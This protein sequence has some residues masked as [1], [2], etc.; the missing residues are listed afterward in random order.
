M[1]QGTTPA[2]QE[3]TS[4]LVLE[5]PFHSLYFRA[6]ID[7]IKRIGR[8]DDSSRPHIK[9]ITQAIKDLG[10]DNPSQLEEF[11][12][13]QVGPEFKYLKPERATFNEGDERLVKYL[14]PFGVTAYWMRRDIEDRGTERFNA[15]R[16]RFYDLTKKGPEVPATS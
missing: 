10:L 13:K 6:A 5:I 2:F 15:L 8:F 4:D 11:A 7:I 14:R 9:D 12:R 1:I 16:L 3:K